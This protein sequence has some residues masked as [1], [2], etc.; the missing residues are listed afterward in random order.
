M[1]TL[2]YMTS[3]LQQAKSYYTLTDKSTGEVLGYAFSTVDSQMRQ[4]QVQMIP[5]NAQNVVTN[6]V[7]D[8]LSPT[9]EEGLTVEGRLASDLDYSQESSCKDNLP[10]SDD[11]V[12]A[13]KVNCEKP[14]KAKA[15]GSYKTFY[16]EMAG[17]HPADKKLRKVRCLLCRD[18]IVSLGNF[19]EHYKAFHE[20][21]VKC[22]ECGREFSASRISTHKMLCR[23]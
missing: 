4:N 5:W 17:C 13:K 23:G 2:P 10:H 15:M 6:D 12:K 1:L 8:Q 14:A 20:P 19:G 11:F 22:T 16:C 18:R 3:L 7:D 9:K 21:P